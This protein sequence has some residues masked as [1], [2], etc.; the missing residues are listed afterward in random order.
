MVAGALLLNVSAVST[1]ASQRGTARGSIY[2]QRLFNRGRQIFRFATFGDQAFWG[3]ALQLHKAIEGS[4]SGGVGPGLSPKGALA[5]GLKVDAA[6]LPRP[7]VRAIKRG[8]VDLNSPKT[9]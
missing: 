9:T 7:V 4:R 1:T 5:A 3:D 6:A 8:K 2:E